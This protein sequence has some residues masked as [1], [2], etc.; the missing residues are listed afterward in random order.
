MFGE[1]NYVVY[2]AKA[3]DTLNSISKL[4][5]VSVA[6]IAKANMIEDV[7]KIEV[8]QDIMIPEVY[9][10]VTT[11]AAT[12]ITANVPA[13]PSVITSALPALGKFNP[14]STRQ[15][16]TPGSNPGTQSSGMFSFLDGTLF[17][18][19]KKIMYPTIAAVTGL[20]AW[21]IIKKKNSPQIA[22]ILP[23]PFYKKRRKRR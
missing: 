4:Y 18:I 13:I 15:Q 10:G 8:G 19:N 3:G 20:A 6:D 22:G 23:N 16:G 11:P 7:N 5:G 14:I 1:D 21:L 9:T 2:T 17:G 12:P